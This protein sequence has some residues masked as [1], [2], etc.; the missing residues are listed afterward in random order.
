VSSSRALLPL[1]LVVFTASGFAGLMYESV[2]THYLKLFLGHSAYAQP[3]VL[4]I[5]MGGM[6]LGAWIASRLSQRLRD[7]LLAYALIEVA[8]GIAAI[9]FHPVFVAATGAAFDRVIPAL[10]SPAAGHAFK[11]A[12]GA[13]LVLPQS[14]LLGMT[15]PLMTGG[16][17]R[18][19]PARPGYV[20]AMLYFTN[21]LGAALGV[22]ASG[23]Y[24]ISTVGL[25]GT[26]IAAG[27]VNLGVAAAV[28][29]L[30]GR[31]GPIRLESAVAAPAGQVPALRLLLAVAALTGMSSF[32]YEI[33]WIRMLALVLGSST[34]AFELMLSAFILGIAF[35]GLWVRRRIDAAGSTVRLLA[36]VQLAM[37]IAALATIPVYGWTFHAMAS[38]LDALARTESGYL[39][40]NVVSHALCLAIMFPAAFCAGMTLPLITVSL[41]RQGAGER[42]IGQVYAANTAGAIVGVL[43]AVHVGFTLL[44]LEGLIAAAAAIDLALGVVLLGAAAPAGS[45]RLP[46]AA[47]ALAAAAV[48]AALLVP[49]DAR[50]M[51]SGVYRVGGLLPEHHALHR[52][53]HGKT[54]TVSI[55]E[56]RGT[57]SV[58]TNGKPDGALRL[59]RGA[60][61]PDEVTMTML[62][63]LPLLLAP[64]ARRVANIGFGTGMTTH[65]LLASPG[66]ERVDS[67]EIEPAMVEAVSAFRRANARAYDDP[68]SHIHYE[69][70]K[71]FFSV[72]RERYDVIVSEPSNPWVSGVA[73]L[74]STEFYRDV[75]RHLNDGGLLVQWVQLYE[76][77]PDL[78]ATIVAALHENFSDYEFWLPGSADLVIVAAH[79]GPVPAASARALAQPALR[80]EL[81]RFSIVSLEDL[82][83]HRVAGRAALAPYFASFRVPPNSDYFPALAMKAPLA[84]YLQS[85]ALDFGML[86]HAP[87]PLLPLFDERARREPE[88]QRLTPGQRP[89]LPRAASVLEAHAAHQYFGS[90]AAQALA[91]LEM[92]AAASLVLLRAAL[93]ECR[94]RLPDG[95]LRHELA[96]LA[97]MVGGQLTSSA[98]AS[99]WGALA[100]APCA[101]QLPDA[102]RRWL[103]LHAAIAGRQPP[104]MASAA[105]AV[106]ES[107]SGLPPEL[108]AHALAAFMAASVL[109]RD[110]EAA[111]AAFN[112]HREV[113]GHMAPEWKPVFRFLLAHAERM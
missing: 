26:L 48:G 100:S 74:F 105:L 42:A 104:D 8:V 90:G 109:T 78:L 23:F 36:W 80:A 22:L 71:T 16:V 25:P 76:I 47:A 7:L 50:L 91:G 53:L 62:G 19:G 82:A 33:G 35:G 98:A 45:R 55:T 30:P 18:L 32:M 46:L 39:V 58:R 51:A 29:L 56:S 106:L 70:A 83:L 59:D 14:I 113:F 15:F 66:V 17:L 49:F 13:A 37:G 1:A 27:V 43:V 103:R 41:L 73:S 95:V 88:A 96:T 81:E 101:A 68:R 72:R 61:A 89:W 52:H 67:I 34:H 85:A 10:G 4:G 110:A 93:M 40:F 102:D 2:W 77:T 75:R 44:G 111:L 108:V 65:V 94:V 107:E 28:M 20:V 24:F 38:T 63:A 97:R 64:E 12:L 92:Q 21:S 86:S 69:D 6:A 3:L 54:A 11:W 9:V 99:L 60:P 57:F 112:R 79:N 84:R 31:K 87:L 5:F